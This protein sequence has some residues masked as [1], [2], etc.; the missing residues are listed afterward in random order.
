MRATST[1]TATFYLKTALL[2]G[3]TGRNNCCYELG[4]PSRCCQIRRLPTPH[5]ISR[6]WTRFFDTV[7][8]MHQPT[9]METKPFSSVREG[10]PI[11]RSGEI[12]KKGT[13]TC[14]KKRARFPFVCVCRANTRFYLQVETSWFG[15]GIADKQ[16]RIVFTC[17][18]YGNR[19]LAISLHGSRIGHWN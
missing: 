6:V 4:Q 9:K 5:S 8:I 14:L 1:Y 3:S 13:V 7:L 10:R 17:V 19:V 2:G 18:L 15:R 12:Q 11:R 16:K